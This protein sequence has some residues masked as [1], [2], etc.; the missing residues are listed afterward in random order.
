MNRL[1]SNFDNLKRV[2]VYVCIKKNI[3]GGLCKKS[4]VFYWNSQFQFKI[5]AIDGDASN[6]R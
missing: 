6:K 3:A 2:T 1:I 5:A 4:E